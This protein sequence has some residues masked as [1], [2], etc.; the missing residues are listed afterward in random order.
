MFLQMKKK[1]K[2]DNKHTILIWGFNK[3]INGKSLE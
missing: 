3:L 1:K 2:G